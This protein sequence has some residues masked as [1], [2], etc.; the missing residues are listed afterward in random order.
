MQTL[1]HFLI[2]VTIFLFG[3]QAS[4]QYVLPDSI[5][6]MTANI[7]QQD[8]Y[9][10]FISRYVPNPDGL[11]LLVTV[12][13]DIDYAL[14]AQGLGIPGL[15]HV[16]GDTESGY[17][18]ENTTDPVLPGVEYFFRLGI[19]AFANYADMFAFMNGGGTD[20]SLVVYYGYGPIWSFTA[21]ISTGFSQASSAE[22]D[23]VTLSN[24]VP[25]VLLDKAEDVFVRDMSGRTLWQG[26]LPQGQHQLPLPRL[27]SSGILA[28]STSSG[29]YQKISGL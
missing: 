24:G 26:R 13:Y 11:V 23:L 5:D 3:G 29:R 1:R 17:T 21:N 18:C 16:I 20:M 7:E 19:H 2:V 22:T 6:S 25:S 4:A 15:S 14:V 28:I 12:K 9:K 8:A 10:L 27:S